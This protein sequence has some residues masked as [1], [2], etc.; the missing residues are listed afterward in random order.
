MDLQ[1]WCHGFVLLLRINAGTILYLKNKIQK[2]TY[3]EELL[4]Q[5]AWVFNS[6]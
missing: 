2:K 5:E 1:L 3:R 4:H 6:T